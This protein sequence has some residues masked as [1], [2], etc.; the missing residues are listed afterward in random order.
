MTNCA[1]DNATARSPTGG[2]SSV[3]SLGA[4]H[5]WSTSVTGLQVKPV[6]STTTDQIMPAFVCTSA[7][8]V[9]SPA[10]WVQN[11]GGKEVGR[12]ILPLK[13]ADLQFINVSPTVHRRAHNLALGLCPWGQS[14]NA[15]NSHASATEM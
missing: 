8:C 13:T 10:E 2:S 9:M 3:P 7:G 11:V 12:F 4:P 5:T 14:R 6:A 1:H 15:P